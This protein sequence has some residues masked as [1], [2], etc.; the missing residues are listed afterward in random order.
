MRPAES[1]GVVPPTVRLTQTISSSQENSLSRQDSGRR[2][3]N[4]DDETETLTRQNFRN[5]NNTEV[6]G[7]PEGRRDEEEHGRDERLVAQNAKFL[8][9]IQAL[10]QV[11][12]LSAPEH[13]PNTIPPTDLTPPTT[14]SNEGDGGTS[15]GV[16][17][18]PSD[19][20]SDA[21]LVRGRAARK[22]L[23]SVAA[24]LS[25]K[26]L[27]F[28]RDAIESERERSQ[29]RRANAALEA[30]GDSKVDDLTQENKKL[31]DAE[32]ST[33]LRLE[34]AKREA[35]A[36]RERNAKLATQLNE[37]KEEKK[38]KKALK[39]EA[40]HY[41]DLY[42]ESKNRVADLQQR[43]TELERGLASSQRANLD[44]RA[45]KDKYDRLKAKARE[46]QRDVKAY[47]AK[48]GA[49]PS[50]IR[51]ENEDL[52]RI[53]DDNGSPG[54]RQRGQA[55]PG[56]AGGAGGEGE[57]AA[58]PAPRNQ[59]KPPP[60]V[61]TV[62]SETPQEVRNSQSESDFE[63][64]P[65]VSRRRK[66]SAAAAAANHSPGWIPRKRP[67]AQAQNAG[68]ASGR[69]KNIDE[70]LVSQMKR[71]PP[72]GTARRASLSLDRPL[73]AAAGADADCQLV[74]DNGRPPVEKGGGA[75]PA[76]KRKK[77]NLGEYSKYR[78]EEDSQTRRDGQTPRDFWHIGVT[79]PA[80]D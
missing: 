45:L 4:Q 76:Q 63:S 1:P 66:N 71:S 35:D 74:L 3:R 49:L 22:S 42:L 61:A 11:Q 18:K 53:S 14:Q 6:A 41:S 72:A 67:G 75:S 33:S 34:H 28:E 62:S 20:G 12:G 2:N 50:S 29:L 69:Q 52:D 68:E 25:R 21:P 54:D 24:D 60:A 56:P 7:A 77:I 31:K 57:E 37:L 8:R 9:D 40:R 30:R 19:K 80:K 27:E 70:F 47:R 64:P 38:Q 55:M 78:R 58:P 65:G 17:R 44:Y 51:S 39:E 13:S 36:F 46:Y 10:A 15:V 5:H 26:I 16:E 32:E 59:I 43:N 73:A 79:P 48:F 23:L